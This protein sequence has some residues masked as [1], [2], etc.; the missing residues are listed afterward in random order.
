MRCVFLVSSDPNPIGLE[1]VALQISLK[2]FCLKISLGKVVIILLQS[3][4]SL[5]WIWEEKIKWHFL[6]KVLL[7]KKMLRCSWLLSLKNIWW[8]LNLGYYIRVSLFKK[9]QI[10]S[11]NHQF[12]KNLSFPKTF[13]KCW[14][15][16][17]FKI[18]HS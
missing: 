18:V 11:V 2:L 6:T 16:N 7:K 17:V 5:L 15:N 9:F 12:A 14:S 4:F 10:T 13:E 8:T 1:T 3:F